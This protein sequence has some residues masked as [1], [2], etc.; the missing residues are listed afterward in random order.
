MKAHRDGGAPDPDDDGSAL[1]RDIAFGIDGNAA[2]FQVSGWAN[3]EPGFTWAVGKESTLVLP[4]NSNADLMMSLA[5]WPSL[6]PIFLPAQR[7]TVLAEGVEIG[8]FSLTRK[9]R[10]QCPIPAERRSRQ[11]HLTITFL[12]PDATRPTVH[13]PEHPDTRELS[14][15]FKRISLH[16]L[17]AR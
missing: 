13:Q 11:P 4:R 6:H 17:G 7:M 10:L 3:P 1:D 12:S 16:R 2:P 9:T 14:F 5:C 15:A 8:Q